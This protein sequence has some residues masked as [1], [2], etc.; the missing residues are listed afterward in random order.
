MNPVT[1]QCK[2][3]ILGESSV[4]KTSLALRIVRDEFFEFSEPTIGAAFLS[5]SVE[6]SNG[7][8]K[9]EIWDTAGQERYR[10]LAPMYYRGASVAL[11]VYDITN[12]DSFSRA[13]HWVNEL[14][15][16]GSADILI[17][18]VGNKI[19]REDARE[20]E[21]ECVQEFADEHCLKHI[22][23]SAKTGV[24]IPELFDSLSNILIHKLA[25]NRET[26]D[27]LRFNTKPFERKKGCC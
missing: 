11:V 19:D 3:V 16:N 17:T 13:Q 21:K 23:T 25:S 4:G 8:I 10:S 2:M 1:R 22:E 18:L 9:Y 12:K 27:T 15:R 6:T 7:R 20:I 14:K 5:H 24:N 26:D